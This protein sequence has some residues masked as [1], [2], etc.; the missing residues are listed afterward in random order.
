[1]RRFRGFPILDQQ[2]HSGMWL[3]TLRRYLL[4]IV[5]GNLLWEILQLP[6]YTIWNEG[7]VGEKAFAV[8]HCTGGDVLIALSSLVLA[9]VL[10]GDAAWPVSRFKSVAALAVTFGIAYT[11]YS[12][13]LNTAVRQNWAYSELMPVIPVIG[14]GLA[15]VAQWI[16]IPVAGLLWARGEG[17]SNA[18]GHSRIHLPWSKTNA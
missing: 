13:W 4:F 18:A 3:P 14:A 12:E 16:V 11:I 10:M 2:A 15:P 7:T 9:L 6:L 1:M 5:G 17:R 8:V